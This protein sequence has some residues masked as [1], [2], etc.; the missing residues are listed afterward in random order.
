MSKAQKG[1]QYKLE[2]QAS[3]DLGCGT[4]LE[5]KSVLTSKLV[6]YGIRRVQPR[7]LV[8]GDQASDQQPHGRI[9]CGFFHSIKMNVLHREIH[10]HEHRDTNRWR[11]FGSSL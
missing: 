5:F 11:L 6:V 8:S 9:S 3:W 4:E 7:D 1:P 2:A 10:S